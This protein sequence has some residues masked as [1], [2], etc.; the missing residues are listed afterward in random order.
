M[1]N[2]LKFKYLSSLTWQAIY[3]DY[4]SCIYFVE[5]F[6]PMSTTKVWL[7]P[8]LEVIVGLLRIRQRGV[9]VRPSAASLMTSYRVLASCQQVSICL[10]RR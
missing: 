4:I 7:N 1:V 8:G 9:V 5:Y 3:T 2:I 10:G 6:T